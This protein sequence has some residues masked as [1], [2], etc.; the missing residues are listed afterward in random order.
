MN[1]K[2]RKG[3]GDQTSTVEQ[4][5]RQH[6]STRRKFC[7]R[8]SELLEALSYIVPLT[9]WTIRFVQSNSKVSVVNITSKTLGSMDCLVLLWGFAVGLIKK[10]LTRLNAQ[11]VALHYT[12]I[13]KKEN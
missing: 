10:R 4:Y 5:L 9:L 3:K 8:F 12:A 13:K 2:G 7:N 6:H 11:G 1:G